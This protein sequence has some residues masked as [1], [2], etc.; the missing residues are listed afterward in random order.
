MALSGNRR[1]ECDCHDRRRR[2]KRGLVRLLEVQRGVVD[3]GAGTGVEI[4]WVAWNLK[5]GSVS[6]RRGP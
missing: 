6:W 3:M 1:E 5:A 4:E 2:P